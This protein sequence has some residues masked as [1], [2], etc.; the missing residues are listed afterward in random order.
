MALYHKGEG[1]EKL[2]DSYEVERHE[3]A[4]ATIKKVNFATNV[5]TLKNPITRTLRNQLA[6]ILVNTDGA[7]H[8][9]YGAIEE[10]LY[11]IRPDHHIGYRSQ[12]V[13]P[14]LFMSY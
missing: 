9:R 14:D 5:V 2:L 8:R 4:E 1:T 11:L 13:M 12:P 3:V 6:A 7:I 10:A